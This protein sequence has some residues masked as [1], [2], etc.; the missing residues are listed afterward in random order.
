M[1][2]FHLLLL[3]SLLAV[4]NCTSHEDL[5]AI[6][7]FNS[8][9]GVDYTVYWNFDLEQQN[10]NFAVRVRTEGWVGFGLSLNGQM[11]YSDVVIGWV[12]GQ[13]TYFDVSHVYIHNH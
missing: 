9:L 5:L 3:A 8:E 10:I 11:P 6:Y 4:S 7:R 1:R 2:I 12:E 13:Q